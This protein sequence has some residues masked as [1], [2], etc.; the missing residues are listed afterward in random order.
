MKQINANAQKADVGC[1]S[2]EWNG[3]VLQDAA[4]VLIVGF[5]EKEMQ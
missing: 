3:S 2:S 4:S 5:V 1:D